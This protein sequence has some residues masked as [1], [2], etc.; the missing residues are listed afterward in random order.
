MGFRHNRRRLLRSAFVYTGA[1]DDWH[2]F[3][4]RNSFSGLAAV[5]VFSIIAFDSCDAET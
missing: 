1:A 5:L 4:A 3:L 2:M